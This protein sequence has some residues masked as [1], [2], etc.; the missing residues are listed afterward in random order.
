[1]INYKI[2]GV[3]YMSYSFD[4]KGAPKLI[5]IQQALMMQVDKG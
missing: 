5:L 4:I 3:D 2:L 1:M